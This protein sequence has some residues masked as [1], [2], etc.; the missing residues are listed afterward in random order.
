ML[1]KEDFI[2]NTTNLLTHAENFLIFAY[3]LTKDQE[4]EENW[5]NANS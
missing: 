2:K 1:P 5:I 3:P 4:I